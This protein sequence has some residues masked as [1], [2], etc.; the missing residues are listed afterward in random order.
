MS[1]KQLYT[2]KAC[3]QCDIAYSRKHIVNGIGNIEADIVIINA[4]PNYTEDAKGIPFMSKGNQYLKHILGSVG[5]S[6]FN[7]YFTNLIKCKPKVNPTKLEVN[8]C[9]SHL[10]AELY[11]IQPK[12]IIL[13]G[14]R[15]HNLFFNNDVSVYQAVKKVMFTKKGTP[16]V[17]IYNPSYVLANHA[18]MNDAY[19]KQLNKIYKLY[20]IYINPNYEQQKFNLSL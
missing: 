14:G 20:T 18:N 11:T 7:F 13:V 2:I 6:S 4:A 16:I 15:T 12:L 1:Y 10:L 17:T 8:N 9:S 19:V 3:K 5:F